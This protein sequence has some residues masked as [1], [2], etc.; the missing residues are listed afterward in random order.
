[1]IVLLVWDERGN[2]G[3]SGVGLKV[4][5]CEYWFNVIGKNLVVVAD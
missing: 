5:C 1:M 2:Y 4:F 3:L